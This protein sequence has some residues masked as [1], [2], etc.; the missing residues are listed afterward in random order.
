[1]RIILMFYDIAV[2][3]KQVKVDFADYERILDK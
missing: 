2:P 1:M 3:G